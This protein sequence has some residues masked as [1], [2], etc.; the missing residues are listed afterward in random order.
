MLL[1]NP[2]QIT[3]CTVLQHQPPPALVLKRIKALENEGA[4]GGLKRL[5]LVPHALARLECQRLTGVAFED[6]HTIAVSAARAVD[7]KPACILGCFCV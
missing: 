7:D 1:H 6:H 2:V 4:V 5:H 3:T